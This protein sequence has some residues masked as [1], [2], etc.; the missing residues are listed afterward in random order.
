VNI[1]PPVDYTV[2]LKILCYNE[3]H[4][5]MTAFYMTLKKRMYKCILRQKVMFFNEIFPFSFY[6]YLLEVDTLPLNKTNSIA[7]VV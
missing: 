3:A 7:V 5:I 4:T 6:V 2:E 1:V